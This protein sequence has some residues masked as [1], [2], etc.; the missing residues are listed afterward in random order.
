[1]QLIYA[2][3]FLLLGYSGQIDESDYIILRRAL[4]GI[5]EVMGIDELTGT[6]LPDLES[7]VHTQS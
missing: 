7:F 6:V 1:L 2:A 5:V 3:G 4:L